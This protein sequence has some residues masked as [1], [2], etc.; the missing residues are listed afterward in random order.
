LVTV[1]FTV[2]AK[3][4]ISSDFADNGCGFLVVPHG[5]K[6]TV[7]EVSA[8]RPLNENDLAHEIWLD[9]PAFFHLL[10]SQ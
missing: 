3:A 5:D 1:D 4:D 6:F 8:V 10:G 7:P 2:A 9:P